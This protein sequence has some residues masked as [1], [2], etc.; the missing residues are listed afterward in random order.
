MNLGKKNEIKSNQI[1][2]EKVRLSLFADDIS[3]VDKLKNPTK[4]ML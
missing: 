2:S 3:Y 1:R 4:E